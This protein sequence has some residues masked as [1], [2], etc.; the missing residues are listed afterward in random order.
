VRGDLVEAERCYRRALTIKRAL[1][2]EGHPELALAMNNLA[3]L[4]R[5]Q[6]RL[7]EARELAEQA[8]AIGEGGFVDG[9]P[10]FSWG[11]GIRAAEPAGRGC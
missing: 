6:G 9:A 11:R 5:K 3:V 8:I 4:L 1:Y 2:D 7:P 10:H